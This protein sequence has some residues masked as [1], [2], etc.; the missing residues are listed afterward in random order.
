MTN[1]PELHDYKQKAGLTRRTVVKGAA[2]AAPV[3]AVSAIAPQ[4]SASLPPC[5]G[6]LDVAGGTYPVNVALAGCQVSGT[7]WD[8]QF[9]FNVR[10]RRGLPCAL[11]CR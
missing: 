9:R 4:A 6:N 2:W 1:N 11:M 8:F 10:A 5:V 3:I 7:H